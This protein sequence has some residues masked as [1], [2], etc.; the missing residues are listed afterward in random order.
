MTIFSFFIPV[1]ML[2]LWMK[3]GKNIRSAS[4]TLP[5]EQAAEFFYAL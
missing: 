2:F 3:D 5:A 4:D 1:F